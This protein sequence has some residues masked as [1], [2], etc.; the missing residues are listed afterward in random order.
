MYPFAEVVLLTAME[1]QRT[2]EEDNIPNS[3]CIRVAPVNEE[4]IDAHEG[5]KKKWYQKIDLKW[6][7]PS[8]KT[9][10]EIEGMFVSLKLLFFREES[11]PIADVGNYHHLL[12]SCSNRL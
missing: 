7:L 3:G 1:Y 12:W 2:E 6:L 9:L 4:E 8:L 10:G 5:E 11:A